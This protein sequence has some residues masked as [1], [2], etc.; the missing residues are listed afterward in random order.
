[1]KYRYSWLVLL[2]ICLLSL[3]SRAQDSLN[4]TQVSQLYAYWDQ[5]FAVTT[6]GD[7][8]YVA[9]GYTG[10]RI[11]DISNPAAPVELG[12]CETAG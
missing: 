11:L 1:M 6:S 8:A 7:Y 3:T 10:L 12:F 4:V 2:L 5:A 9:S